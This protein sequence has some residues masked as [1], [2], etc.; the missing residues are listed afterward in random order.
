[1]K[2]RLLSVTNDPEK[3][4]EMAA[5]VCVKKEPSEKG[6]RAAIDSGHLS[7]AEHVTFTFFVHGVSRSL[8]AQL[9]RH[10]IAS[11]SVESQRY[12]P[13]EDFHFITPESIRTNGPLHA[14]YL[15]MMESIK[16]FY[17]AA[18]KDGV[19]KEDARFILPN[20]ASTNL[21]MTMNA[22]EILHFLGLRECNRAQW[23]IRK[24]AE[25][26]RKICLKV[27]P[28]LFENSGAP[29]RRGKCPEKRPCG[30]PKGGNEA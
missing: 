6:M 17:L 8:L 3:I 4:M 18:V 16:G 26:I 29:C 10:R 15:E 23:E 25:E 7:I 14:A 24:L 28:A 5:A 19:P 27:S 9:T 20:A 12:V 1:M 2:V 13:A 22:R 21:I 30:H 11:F